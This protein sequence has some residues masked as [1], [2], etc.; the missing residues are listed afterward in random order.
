MVRQ[1]SSINFLIFFVDSLSMARMSKWKK[2]LN[3]TLTPCL[4]SHSNVKLQL[5]ATF[6]VSNLLWNED[7]GKRQT[8]WGVSGGG[9]QREQGVGSIK[10]LSS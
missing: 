10:D 8:L 4:Q 2:S 7:N 9:G 6:C 1:N 5:A 3:D